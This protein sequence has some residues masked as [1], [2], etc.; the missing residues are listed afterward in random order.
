MYSNILTIRDAEYKLVYIY[1]TTA[2]GSSDFRTGVTGGNFLNCG[3]Y[4]TF[5]R[6][7]SKN[8]EN[9]RGN[10]EIATIVQ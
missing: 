9:W 4:N 5:I 1:L 7:E 6:G 8:N 2:E 3:K 10:K